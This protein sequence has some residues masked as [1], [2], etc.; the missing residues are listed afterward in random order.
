[1]EVN[2]RIGIRVW[3]QFDPPIPMEAGMVVV[4][5]AVPTGF[6]LV[7]ETLDEVVESEPCI[8]RYDVA[9]R[10]AP[11]WRA[12]PEGFALKGSSVRLR[13]RPEGL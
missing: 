11:P 2:D 13:L 9:A 4:D 5:I 1:M 10:K 7:E 3:V 8:K 6:V 12:H